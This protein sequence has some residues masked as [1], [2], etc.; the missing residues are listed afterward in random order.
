MSK[1]KDFGSVILSGQTRQL[2]KRPSRELPAVLENEEQVLQTAL[3]VEGISL[4]LRGRVDRALKL[5]RFYLRVFRKVQVQGNY[6]IH[7]RD[8]ESM[9]I[10]MEM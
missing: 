5:T 3:S 7:K 6:S 1:T 8:N 4:E 2:L 10:N 9:E